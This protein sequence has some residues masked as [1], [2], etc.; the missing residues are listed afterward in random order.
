MPKKENSAGEMQ[1][2]NAENGRY[3]SGTGGGESKK[4]DKKLS[5]FK[6]EPSEFEKANDKRM[7]KKLN[8]VEDWRISEALD[9]ASWSVT[10][11]TLVGKYAEDIAE[12]LDIDKEDVLRVMSKEAGR[13]LKEDEN[14]A[15]ILFPEDFEEED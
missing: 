1:N 13:E 4:E 5:S 10:Q 14:L 3:E 6:K 11:N 2:Y 7:G 15:K 8:K 12:K 9:D